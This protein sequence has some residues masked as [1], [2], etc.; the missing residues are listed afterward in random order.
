MTLSAIAGSPARAE[1]GVTL[2]E[3]GSESFQSVMEGTEEA[4]DF[5]REPGSAMMP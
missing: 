1:V 2:I 3:G 4:C 5:A